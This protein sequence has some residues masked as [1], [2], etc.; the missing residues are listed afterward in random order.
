MKY[1]ILIGDGMADYPQK[2]L[3][4]KTPLEYAK[5]P[6][7]DFIAACG[8]LGT[9]KTIPEGFPPGSDVAN[10]SLFGYD[11]TTCYSG[12]APLEA[13]SMGVHLHPDDVAFRCN[14]VTLKKTEGKTIMEDFAC[15][16]I[17][18]AESHEIIKD[19]DR[20]LGSE[21]IK[22][23]PGISY[24]HLLV[25]KHG[26]EEIEL[27]PPHDITGQNIESYMPKGEKSEEVLTMMKKSMAVL[28]KHPVNLKRI[29]NGQRPASTIWL[30]GEG[31]APKM[32]T[33]KE[34]Y[35]LA[36]A[37]IS[38][39]DLIK[40]IGVYAGLDV[41]EVPGATGF[42]DT[43]YQGKAEYALSALKEKDIVFVHVEAP[44]EAAHMGDLEKKLAAIEDFDEKVVGT[45]L[46]GLHGFDKCGVLVAPDHPTPLS[47]M[48]HTAEAVPFAFCSVEKGTGIKQKDIGFD[49][50]SAAA[51]GI[52]FEKGQEL[53]DR[54]VLD[55]R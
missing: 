12:R 31:R 10:L 17:S 3:D 37:V 50:M 25:W 1:L 28:E 20:D 4:G 42:L 41:I 13:A 30:W 8:V 18:S 7:M 15:G 48:T 44:D 51:S 43:N 9:V 45:V 38:A 33:M 53:L 24:R 19:L 55:E 6:N 27:T 23:Y 14:I 34:K 22:L 11:P 54:F 49:E 36:G 35:N 21:E 40:G 32:E 46:K 39:V 16:H 52:H 5:T 26:T 29:E 47:I 2:E